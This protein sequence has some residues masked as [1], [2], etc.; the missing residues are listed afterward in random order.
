MARKSAKRDDIE[1]EH[2]ITRL[3]PDDDCDRSLMGKVIWQAVAMD[4]KGKTQCGCGKELTPTNSFRCVYCGQFFCVQCAE[5][6]FGFTRKDY[7]TER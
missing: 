4:T 7:D 3:N 5:V 6:H 2:Y 1:I